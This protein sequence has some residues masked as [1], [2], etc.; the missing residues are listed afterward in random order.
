MGSPATATTRPPRY[1]PTSRHSSERSKAEC[2]T[3]SAAGVE[4]WS[5][6]V[7]SCTLL[8]VLIAPFMMRSSEVC[9]IALRPTQEPACSLNVMLYLSYP[10]YPHRFI[11]AGRSQATAIGR[12]RHRSYSID[13]AAE[14][15]QRL[16][17]HGIPEAHHSITVSRCKPATVW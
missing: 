6:R 8:I 15:C 3:S 11:I 7:P 14:R 4:D 1:G 5:L 10:P 12:P 9:I 17:L 13:M 16:A 2:M